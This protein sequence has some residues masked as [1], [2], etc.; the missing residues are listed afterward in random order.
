MTYMSEQ[1]KHLPFQSLGTRLKT[2]R[3]KLQESVADVSGAIEID[4][5]KLQRIEQGQERPSE[6]I[7]LLLISHFGMREEEA[8]NLWLL[9]G[10]DQPRSQEVN[11]NADNR[12]TIM[13]MGIDPRV[14][15]SDSVHIS[16]N[17]GGV[18]MNFSQAGPGTSSNQPLAIA[19]IGMSRDQAKNVMKVLAEALHQ[20]DNPPAPKGLPSGKAQQNENDKNN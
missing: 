3:Q 4:E 2:I 16:V 1:P 9:A 14:I 8:A 20:F 10:Y 18:V 12:P 11:D 5:E 7:L 6:D 15:Y 17:P 19:R 13:L